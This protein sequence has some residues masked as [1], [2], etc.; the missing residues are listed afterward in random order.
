MSY[1][2]DGR[3][4]ERGEARRLSGPRW[5]GVRDGLAAAA[6]RAGWK[7]E[8]CVPLQER[9]SVGRWA[10]APSIWSVGARL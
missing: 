10:G 4:D 9:Q 3:T 5:S 6:G 1:T 7:L 2:S 8:I